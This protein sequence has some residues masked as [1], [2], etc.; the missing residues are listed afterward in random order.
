[1]NAHDDKDFAIVI[2]AILAV[3]F[4][5]LF[6][7]WLVA[8]GRRVDQ[9][10]DHFVDGET[11]RAQLAEG[12]ADLIVWIGSPA[13][14][15]QAGEPILPP[16]PSA[17]IE[18]DG[19]LYIWSHEL[20]GIPGGKDGAFFFDTSCDRLGGVPRTDFPI[21]VLST[22]T[23]TIAPFDETGGG[24]WKLDESTGLFFWEEDA[25]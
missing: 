18:I 15:A 7:I 3:A 21:E 22:G 23:I 9:S 12:P 4:G 6:C 16:E 8:N 1:M 14:M 24:R 19:S 25:Q 10:F 20:L 13:T 11:Y 5:C 2:G 17:R